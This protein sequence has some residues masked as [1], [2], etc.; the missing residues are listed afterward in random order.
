M[1][2]SWVQVKVIAVRDGADIG[3]KR[4]NGSSPACD[5]LAENGTARVSPQGDQ[6]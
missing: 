1:T 2:R 4:V 6:R 5:D 3:F